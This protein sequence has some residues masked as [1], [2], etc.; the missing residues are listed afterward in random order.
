MIHVEGPSAWDRF[1]LDGPAHF[2]E[3]TGVDARI[4]R[5]GISL[6]RDFSDRRLDFVVVDTERVSRDDFADVITSWRDGYSEV[7]SQH[8]GRDVAEVVSIMDGMIEAIRTRYA[9]WQVPIA[10]GRRAS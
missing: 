7:L 8:M 1:W 9:L 10:S 6:L 2:G 5:R 4:G 3:E